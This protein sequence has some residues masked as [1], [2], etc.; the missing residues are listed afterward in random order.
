M[1]YTEVQEAFSVLQNQADQQAAL[2]AGHTCSDHTLTL[3]VFEVRH[4]AVTQL[5]E[6]TRVYI[7]YC[8]VRAGTLSRC[9]AGSMFDSWS[10]ISTFIGECCCRTM[11]PSA[12]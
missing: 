9:T 5:F 4:A 10:S 3:K 1:S 6:Q 7:T 11:P 2:T 12:G 8:L